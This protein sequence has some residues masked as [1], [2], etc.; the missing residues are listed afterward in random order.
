MNKELKELV[1]QRVVEKLI[2]LKGAPADEQSGR[3]DDIV[4]LMKVLNDAEKNETEALKAEIDQSKA[5]QVNEIDHEKLEFEREKLA[6][7]E[8]LEHEK[9]DI[10]RVKLSREIREA[11]KELWV[12]FATNLVK[13]VAELIAAGLPVF[14]GAKLILTGYKYEQDN[15][16]CSP[17]LKGLISGS[18]R[19]MF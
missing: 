19:K 5:E 9:I 13:H 6:K 14:I 7:E 8:K 18:L 1:E 2:D 12:E 3:I 17:T 10:D 11:E 4:Q 16:V 15:I